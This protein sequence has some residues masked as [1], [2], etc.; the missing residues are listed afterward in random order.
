MRVMMND[1]GLGDFAADPLRELVDEDPSQVEAALLL[2]EILERSGRDD[3]LV[4]LYAKQID[5]AKDRSDAVSVGSLS[6]RLAALQERVS[7]VDAKATLYSALEWRP[8]DRAILAALARLH[9]E[10]GDTSDRADI[11]ERQLVLEK[12]PDATS[13]ALEL[14]SLREALG[15]ESGTDRALELG[16]RAHPARALAERLEKVFRAREAW[17]KLADLYALEAS[18]ETDAGRRVAR[19]RDAAAISNKN[20]AEPA[21]AVAFLREARKNAAEDR[22]LLEQLVELLASM[23]ELSGAILELSSLIDRPRASVPDGEGTIPSGDAGL[24]PLLARRASI[25]IGLGETEAAVEDLEQSFRLGGAP[26]VRELATQLERLRLMAAESGDAR[27]ERSLRLRLAEVLPLAGDVESARTLLTELVR[28][29]PKDRDALR[30]LARIEEGAQHWDAVTA[31]Y[32]RLIVLEEGAAVVETALRLADACE[33]AG[34]FADARGALER[35]RL[36]APADEGLRERL[37]SLYEQTGAFKELAEMSLADAKDAKEV[38]ARFSHLVRAGALFLQHGTEREVAITALEEARALR[39]SDT[40]CT[41]L[42]AD[43]YTLAGHSAEAAELINQAILSHKG[44]RSRDL[45]AL[46]HRLARVAHHSGDQANEIAWLS[47]A[48]DM[49]AQNGFVA[50]ELANVAMETG[51]FEVATRA[52]RAITMIKTAG[53]SPISKAIAYQHLGEIARQQGDTKKAVMLLKRAI[54]DDPT[55]DSARSLLNSLQAD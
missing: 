16:Y 5:A 46:Y 6:L 26:F 24:A 32:R 44:R 49:D 10:D 27:A 1:Q 4:A 25:R 33:R 51:Q 2:A 7:R 38:P 18:F 12:G 39:P 20:L 31:T 28:S 40:E 53:A 48:L 55:L 13:I 35:A 34:R 17:A 19:L 50:S 22:T 37:S 11:L 9:G 52:L 45:G 15:D 54:D 36:V 47:S 23:G 14:S 8:E 30:L 42:L 21:R 3:E 43:A 41:V 29:K